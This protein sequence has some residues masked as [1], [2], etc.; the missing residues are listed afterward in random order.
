MLSFIYTGSIE[1]AAGDECADGL[2][3]LADRY[4]LLDL[5]EH[6]EGQMAARLDEANLI[7]V[8]ILANLHTCPLL[9]RVCSLI[10]VYKCTTD[11]QL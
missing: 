9:M 5:K 7:D 11:E 2:L 1:P 8:A 3:Q 10:R 4:A 6:M